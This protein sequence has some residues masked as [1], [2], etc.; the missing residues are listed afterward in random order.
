MPPEKATES[1]QPLAIVL[2]EAK[3]GS[4]RIVI[5]GAKKLFPWPTTGRQRT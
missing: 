4:G 1:E 5:P 2:V 3:P